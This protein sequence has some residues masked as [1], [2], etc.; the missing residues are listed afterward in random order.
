MFCGNCGK[1][2]ENNSNFCNN[3]G[4][5]VI[6][7]NSSNQGNMKEY[8]LEEVAAT[9]ICLIAYAVP[10]IGAIFNCFLAL[11]V[12]VEFQII[13]FLTILFNII[14]FAI[15]IASNAKYSKYKKVRTF[16]LIYILITVLIIVALL[17]SF[18]FLIK[19]CINECQQM[20]W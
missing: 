19:S 9:R 2:I 16:L 1:K 10:I 20:S 18:I 11:V 13:V 6:I 8:D 12:K 5:Q 3:C 15:L 14:G 17:I 4:N 7:S